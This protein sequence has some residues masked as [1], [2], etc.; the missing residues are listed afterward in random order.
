MKRSNVLTTTEFVVNKIWRE[1]VVTQLHQLNL[2]TTKQ[3]R[4][5]RQLEKHDCNS[6]HERKMLDTKYYESGRECLDRTDSEGYDELT[7][8]DRCY[9][10]SRMERWD[11]SPTGSWSTILE[12]TLLWKLKNT[13]N[14]TKRRTNAGRLQAQTPLTP[15][16]RL[17]QHRQQP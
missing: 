12:P 9:D 15:S 17:P 2:P 7:L 3:K 14:P 11:T 4:P 1:G 10:A 16:R 13:S 5:K 8:T 6:I